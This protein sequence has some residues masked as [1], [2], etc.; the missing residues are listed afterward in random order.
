MSM[1][2]TRINRLW[3][4][5]NKAGILKVKYESEK[6]RVITHLIQS[7][8]ISTNFLG[9]FRRKHGDSFESLKSEIDIL[10]KLISYNQIPLYNNLINY[11]GLITEDIQEAKQ[12]V[13][14]PKYLNL[15]LGIEKLLTSV[16]KDYPKV[17][18]VLFR[19]KEWLEKINSENMSVV[20]KELY[21]LWKLENK[22]LIRI[23]VLAELMFK[24]I[25][26]TSKKL[27]N[28]GLGSSI[29]GMEFMATKSDY[30]IYVY[31]AAVSA[32]TIVAFFDPKLAADMHST[33]QPL[34]IFSKRMVMAN[35]GG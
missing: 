20:L 13:I 35:R 14:D 28:L 19:E 17:R 31:L 30:L 26:R 24:E 33:L 1:D 22:E 10:Y 4:W 15:L 18:E 29:R 3:E 8:G 16:Q 27:Y 5:A 7:G 6:K 32:S 34:R 21:L 25:S 9:F 2:E 11:S 12:K 23:Q